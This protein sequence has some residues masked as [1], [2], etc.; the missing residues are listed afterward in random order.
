MEMAQN[1]AQRFSEQAWID[2]PFLGPVLPDAFFR[3]SPVS[4]QSSRW[5]GVDVLHKID[6]HNKARAVWELEFIP[7]DSTQ[8]VLPVGIV[9]DATADPPR[10]RVYCNKALLGVD[11][12]RGPIIPPEA[13]LV[14]HP[15]MQRYSQALRSADLH[16]L[17]EILDPHLRVRGPGGWIQDADVRT[18]FA[19]RMANSGGVP[20]MYVTCTDDGSRAALEFISWRVPPH[21]GLGVY[22][23]SQSG[24]IVQFRAYEGPVRPRPPSA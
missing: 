10:A 23:R 19:T 16:G 24:R 17:L 1:L 8:S 9:W 14:L 22:D 4:P 13:D 21:A 3:D 2:D 7:A 12:V 18:S 11:E 20:I 6:A 15:T 5:G